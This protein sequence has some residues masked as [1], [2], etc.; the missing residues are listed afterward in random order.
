MTDTFTRMS[1]RTEQMLSVRVPADLREAL[2]RAAEQE[3]RTV[4]QQVRFI[5]ERA[6]TKQQPATAA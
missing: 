2:A 4:S 1:D 5:I 6:V 3:H